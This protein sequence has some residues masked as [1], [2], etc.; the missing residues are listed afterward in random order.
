MNKK[1]LEAWLNS[2]FIEGGKL[3]PTTEGVPQWG[4]SVLSLEIG[5]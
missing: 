5:Y 2:G 4:T 1:V 3:F